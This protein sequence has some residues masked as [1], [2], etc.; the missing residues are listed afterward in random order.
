V[1]TSQNTA[2]VNLAGIPALAV[3]IP[4]REGD[5]PVTSVQLVGP[6]LSEPN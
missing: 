6:R 2:A 1:A 3:P 4:M 5:I